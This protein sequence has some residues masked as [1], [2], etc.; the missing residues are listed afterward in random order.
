DWSCRPG[1]RVTPATPNPF[2]LTTRLLDR[3]GRGYRNLIVAVTLIGLAAPVSALAACDW[4]PLLGG[5][6]AVPAVG[7]GLTLDARRV[8]RWRQDVLA[9]WVAGRLDLAVLRDSFTSVKP[10]PARTLAGLFDPLPTRPPPDADR[11]AMANAVRT[12]DRAA[13]RGMVLGVAGL[14]I[15]VIAAG[16]AAAVWSAWPLTGVLLG[17]ALNWLARRQ[18]PPRSGIRT[19]LPG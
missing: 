8:A 15:L 12:A 19:A 14:T 5:L 1:N 13:V 4:R 17:L 16:T 9:A 3:R 18:F 10:L 6:L 11:Q 2:A 7:V